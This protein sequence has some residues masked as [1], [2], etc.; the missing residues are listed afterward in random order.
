MD[1]KV[2]KVRVIRIG[3]VNFCPV[4]CIYC[5]RV[6]TDQIGNPSRDFIPL[7]TAQNEINKITSKNPDVEMI[8]IIT[9]CDFFG[10]PNAIDYALQLCHMNPHIQ[11]KI[12]TTG[13]LADPKKISKL[14]GV[15]NIS[16]TISINTFDPEMRRQLMRI[17]DFKVVDYMIKNLKCYPIL[18]C[19]GDIDIL[20]RDL[21]VLNSYTWGDGLI[22]RRI[23]WTKLHNKEG[24]AF[25]QKSV[26]YF[27]K[28][29]QYLTDINYDVFYWM[30]E[31]DI[32]LKYKVEPHCSDLPNQVK[33]IKKRLENLNGRCLFVSPDSSY[34]FWDRSLKDV[35]NVDV[36]RVE[37][38]FFGGSIVV[39]GL[40]TINDI[41]FAISTVSNLKQYDLI[42]LPFAMHLGSFKD[43][44]GNP[45]TAL[46]AR[47]GIQ[48]EFMGNVLYGYNHDPG[49]N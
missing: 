23:D 31:T 49:R 34:K 9:G 41:D 25:G 29:V 33:S 24:Q 21:D 38:K 48:T 35:D 6:L 20:K 45:L 7:A 15:P 11:F 40:L 37:N 4:G 46:S 1:Y 44:I 8:D 16:F 28:S 13:V 27:E 22:Y 30:V 42:A 3:G 47:Y 26:S 36:L 32:A 39:A 12:V 17:S 43:C 10:S 5:C 14:D 18:S 2:N 19:V